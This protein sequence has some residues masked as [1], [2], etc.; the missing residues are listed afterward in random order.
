MAAV[1]TAV[2]V[3]FTSWSLLK[4]LE[5]VTVSAQFL[6]ASYVEDRRLA[7]C[8]N[9]MAMEAN[10]QAAQDVWLR[11]ACSA[12]EADREALQ[13]DLDQLLAAWQQRYPEVDSTSCS[14]GAAVQLRLHRQFNPQL[15]RDY[16]NWVVRYFSIPAASPD[17]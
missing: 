14:G 8:A 4:G 17:A 6:L 12:S 11:Q 5:Q 9:L 13:L 7:V 10:L 3:F 1:S 2:L 15:S 16:P